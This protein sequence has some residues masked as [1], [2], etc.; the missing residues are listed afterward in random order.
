MSEWRDVTL[1]DVVELKRG[2]DLPAADRH[3]GT[4]P[5][6]SSS[7]RSGFHDEA[8]VKGPGVVTGRYGTLG[9]VFYIEE[10]FWPLNTSLYVRERGTIRGSW[11]LSSRR[12][13][14]DGVRAPP[15]FPA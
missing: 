13:T 8:K 15:Q 11:R 10:D 9:Q 3:S 12:S 1:G 6:V 7:G 14:S 4:I 5:I 2:Y